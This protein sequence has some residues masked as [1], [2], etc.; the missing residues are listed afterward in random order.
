MR[1]YRVENKNG[2]GP[3]AGLEGERGMW[4]DH[5]SPMDFREANDAALKIALREVNRLPSPYQD[6]LDP[7][8]RLAD[9][10]ELG[11]S[12]IEQLRQWFPEKVVRHM[13]DDFADW[14]YKVVELEA[15][16]AGLYVLSHQV[17]FDRASA[18]LIAEHPISWLNAK[19]KEFA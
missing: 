14:G 5:L 4:D 9:K 1:I 6:G 11:C 18:E 16:D 13:E 19:E 10:A 17:V 7:F 2:F 12:S 15:S 8:N 3:W